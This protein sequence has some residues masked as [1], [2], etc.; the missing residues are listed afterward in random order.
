MSYLP[1]DALD[2]L[3]TALY[4]GNAQ[5]RVRANALVD[6]YIAEP[7]RVISSVLPL[8]MV[9]LGRGAEA[10]EIERTRVTVDNPDFM[11]FLFSPA[12]K[13]LRA[14]AEFPAY[15]KAKGLPALWDA[16][17]PPDICPKASDGTYH[18][19]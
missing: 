13:S 18:C 8:W 17:G 4:G 16:H 10:L 19:N 9:E 2:L 3:A 15:L 11:I 5:D 7:S 1:A 12:G 14:L 6:T